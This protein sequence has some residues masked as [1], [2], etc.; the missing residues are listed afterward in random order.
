MLIT[1]TLPSFAFSVFVVVSSEVDDPQCEDEDGDAES[2][3]RDRSEDLNPI[4]IFDR[5]SLYR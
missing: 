1:T 3:I 4:L 2:N 5:L